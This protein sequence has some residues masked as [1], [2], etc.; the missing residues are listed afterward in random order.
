MPRTTKLSDMQLILLSTASQRD[1]GSL[2]PLPEAMKADDSRLAKA[3][4]GLTT[5]GLAAEVDVTKPALV[6]RQDEERRIGLAI[7]DS[8]REA[9][10]VEPVGASPDDQVGTAE[11]PASSK[12]STAPAQVRPGTKQAQLVQML[13]REGGATIQEIVDATGWL[14]HTTRA[15]LTGLRKRGWQ[16]EGTKE[17]GQS[18]YRGKKTSA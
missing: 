18:R 4:H 14:P 17:D 13:E 2:L 7:T 5:K 10:A 11:T 1:D 9:I 6:W 15:A 3:I 8:G 12:S 16:I